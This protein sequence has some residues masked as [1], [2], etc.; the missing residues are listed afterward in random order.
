MRSPGLHVVQ[1]TGRPRAALKGTPKVALVGGK[2]LFYQRYL[3]LLVK[4]QFFVIL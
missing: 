1:R 4:K 2:V 3:L